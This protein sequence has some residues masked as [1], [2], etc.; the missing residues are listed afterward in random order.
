V[1]KVA[2][3]ELHARLHELRDECDIAREPVELG[4][5]D[6]PLLLFSVLFGL[7]I[8]NFNAFNGDVMRKLAPQFLTL[9]LM[10]GHRIMG[11]SLTSTG[12]VVEGRAHFDRSIALYDPDAHRPLAMRFSI[13]SR[14]STLGF[15]SAAL[16]FLDYPEAALVD[17]QHALEDARE[18]GQAATLMFTLNYASLTELLCGNYGPA[19]ALGDELVALAG[20]KGSP[21]WK[22]IGMMLQGCILAL[23][24][25]VA[26]AVQ[27]ITSGLTA[28]RSMGSTLLV[29]FYSLCLARAYADLGQ[30]DDAWR[31]SGEAT[32]AVEVA[33]EKWFEAEVHRTAGEI[34]LL[35]P[36]PD[37]PKAEAHFERAL[38]V[39]R[40]QQA[41]SWGAPHG[42]EHGE[43]VVRSGEAR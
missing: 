32:T 6:S 23:A 28:Y 29:P 39:A 13:D 38:A 5:D 41:K 35:V 2:G 36:N 31:C 33:K 22:V 20:Q 43:A 9:P 25:R 34:T 40:A 3:D 42:D 30:F 8:A 14:V 4:D 24:G 1:R 16:W 18:I 11:I 17:T 26:D 15:R 19:D 7:F 12:D 10:I 27:V 37:M 21:Y